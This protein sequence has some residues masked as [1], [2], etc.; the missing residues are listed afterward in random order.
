MPGCHVNDFQVKKF[1]K[2]KRTHSIEQAALRSGF[3]RDTGYRIHRDL[4][5]A[6]QKTVPRTRRRP[7]PLAGVFEE[8]IVPMLENGPSVRNT[9]PIR[10]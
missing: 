2:L 4:W 7:D 1:M 3:S 10:R 8:Q 5:L 6:S 9:V